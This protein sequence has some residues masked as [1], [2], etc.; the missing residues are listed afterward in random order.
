MW[1]TEKRR[2]AEQMFY[3]FRSM[4]VFVRNNDVIDSIQKRLILIPAPEI[5]S[6]NNTRRADAFD[7]SASLISRLISL[8]YAWNYYTYP[9]ISITVHVT[10][11]RTSVDYS[12]SSENLSL[13]L[14][15]APFK[16]QKIVYSLLAI[17]WLVVEL[18]LP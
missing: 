15:I 11:F 7:K 10:P 16:H 8:H 12:L 14:H 4:V 2:A 18:N 17:L 5:L 1:K 6:I 3:N 13:L 9:P